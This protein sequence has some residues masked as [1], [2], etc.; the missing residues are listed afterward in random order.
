VTGILGVSGG[1]SGSATASVGGVGGVRGEEFGMEDVE[2]GVTGGDGHAAGGD[3][4]VEVKVRRILVSF[5]L[6]AGSCLQH[7]STVSQMG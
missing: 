7:S 1:R 4:L 2:A 6:C 5:G 3:A